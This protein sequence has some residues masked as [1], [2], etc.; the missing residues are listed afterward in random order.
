MPKKK[1]PITAEDIVNKET[2]GAGLS[3]WGRS[4][5][6]GAKAFLKNRG[7]GNPTGRKV[8]GRLPYTKDIGETNFSAGFDS[9][10][11]SFYGR[12]TRWHDGKGRGS[13]GF[14]SPFQPESYAD[15][16]YSLG[17]KL[18]VG[19]LLLGGVALLGVGVVAAY[20]GITDFFSNPEVKAFVD[21]TTINAQPPSPIESTLADASAYGGTTQ[22]DTGSDLSNLVTPTAE[23]YFACN[24]QLLIEILPSGEIR[25]YTTD[26]EIFMTAIHK[27]GRLDLLKTTFY[28]LS[29]IQNDVAYQGT[30]VQLAIFGFIN[31]L[32][33]HSNFN[34]LWNEQLYNLTPEQLCT[35]SSLGGAGYAQGALVAAVYCSPLGMPMVLGER[36]MNSVKT[37]EPY[38]ITAA[39]KA[40]TFFKEGKTKAMNAYHS[41]LHYAH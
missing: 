19:G 8:W 5:T 39:S 32:R 11:S 29:L 1:I 9:K 3:Y 12:A 31:N 37:F 30:N 38:I 21:S 28:G 23:N 27:E 16:P 2:L 6:D 18:I 41:L 20:N 36:A 7:Q 17:E 24:S 34:E 35:Q 22:N 40:R 25:D 14:D 15:M 10:N 13:M 26:L 4:L 33:A